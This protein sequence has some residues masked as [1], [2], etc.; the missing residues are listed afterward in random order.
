MLFCFT[1]TLVGGCPRTPETTVARHGHGRGA[2]GAGS[3]DGAA[4]HAAT[5]SRSAGRERASTRFRSP[6]LRREDVE[7]LGR[8]PETG[9]TRTPPGVEFVRYRRSHGLG[10][11]ETA[12]KTPRMAV[13]AVFRA[14]Q[15]VEGHNLDG[16]H[17]VGQG[18]AHGRVPRTPRRRAATRGRCAARRRRT[19]GATQLSASRTAA[20]EPAV[21]MAGG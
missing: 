10:F 13:R 17:P 12:A 1:K 21:S 19:A 3:P 4:G 15:G 20:I 18:T 7:F 14:R 8:K 6:I 11:H 2:A 9:G 16:W 5:A